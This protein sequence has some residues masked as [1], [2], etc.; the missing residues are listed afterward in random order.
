MQDLEVS[1]AR[2]STLRGSV[3][4]FENHYPAWAE[5]ELSPPPILGITMAQTTTPMVVF[6]VR[7]RGLGD[8]IAQSNIGVLVFGRDGRQA[9]AWLRTSCH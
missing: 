7:L 5:I 1:E 9:I 4:S 6:G 2:G 3:P 8:Y